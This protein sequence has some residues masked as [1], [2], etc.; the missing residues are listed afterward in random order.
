M[1]QMSPRTVFE[2]GKNDGM[3]VKSGAVLGTL[4]GI[5][6]KATFTVIKKKKN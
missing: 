4:T 5:R 6:N 2:S 3:S 1:W